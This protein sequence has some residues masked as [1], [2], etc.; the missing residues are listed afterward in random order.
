MSRNNVKR[1]TLRYLHTELEF[2]IEDG[3]SLEPV[4]EFFGTHFEVERGAEAV[5]PLAVIRVI[6]DASQF[7]NIA[8]DAGED[9]YI[10]KSASA[11]FTIVAR[12]VSIGGTEYYRC[13]RTDIRIAMDAVNGSI[14]VAGATE[15]SERE[16]MVWIELIRDLVLKNEE[17][18]GVVVVHATCAYQDG[19][20]MMIAGQKG[21]GKS[22]TLLEL[23][24]RFGCSFM[25]GDKTFLWMDGGKLYASGWPDY[26]HLGLGTMSKYPEFVERYGLADPIAAAQETL[27][28]GEHKIAVSPEV[29]KAIIPMTP[30]GLRCPVRLVIYPSVYPSGQ[31]E[32]RTVD[33]HIRRLTPHIERMFADGTVLWNRYVEPSTPEEYDAA[34]QACL[35]KLA[36]I[37]AVTVEGSGII[38]EHDW[39]EAMK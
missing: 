8:W 22:T 25:S 27:W 9:V 23:V 38:G 10:R 24:H 16:N 1:V 31:C 30:P 33:D 2:H 5:N 29:F 14:L 37:S 17:N 36:S 6:R 21:A 19:A 15:G 35:A 20:A 12:R 13:N 11:F 26:P 7:G 18:H 39:L 28:S 4:F 3:I 34:V 32:I